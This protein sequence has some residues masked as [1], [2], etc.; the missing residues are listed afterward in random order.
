M[1]LSTDDA[2]DLFGSGRLLCAPPQPM[3]CPNTLF[4]VS[5]CALGD[6]YKTFN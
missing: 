5:S 1:I 2:Y 6:F 3:A 4:L